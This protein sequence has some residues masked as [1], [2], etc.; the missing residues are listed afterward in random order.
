MSSGRESPAALG[1]AVND[2]E[3]IHVDMNAGKR[4]LAW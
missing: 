1:R 3:F 4:V 2:T